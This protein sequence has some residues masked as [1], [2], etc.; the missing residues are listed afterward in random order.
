[1]THQNDLTTHAAGAESDRDGTRAADGDAPHA[2]EF[3]SPEPQIMPL[4]RA[5]AQRTIAPQ[6][7]D[8]ADQAIGELLT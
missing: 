1:M 8:D 3:C 6:P 5:G 7:I 2:C 4:P